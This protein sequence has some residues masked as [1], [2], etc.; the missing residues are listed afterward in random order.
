VHLVRDLVV[1]GRPRHAL[2]ILYRA[3][4][5]SPRQLAWIGRIPT[6]FGRREVTC[7]D[8]ENQRQAGGSRDGAGE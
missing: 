1:D 6:R 7:A 8:P 4:D 5:H 2:Q 3:R